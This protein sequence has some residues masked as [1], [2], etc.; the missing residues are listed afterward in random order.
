MASDTLEDSELESVNDPAIERTIKAGE[1]IL[2]TLDESLAAAT[3]NELAEKA[4]T[5][6]VRLSA[7]ESILNRRCGKPVERV[8]LTSKGERMYMLPE[9]FEGALHAL[10]K[11]AGDR[12]CVALE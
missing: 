12:A 9:E 6:N 4:S 1:D 8:D 10:R 2:E 7:A 3:I 5:D 11:G